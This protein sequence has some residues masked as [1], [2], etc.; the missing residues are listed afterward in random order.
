MH[1]KTLTLLSGMVFFAI[2]HE[3]KKYFLGDQVNHYE[4]Q[5][6]P[7]KMNSDEWIMGS[8]RYGFSLPFHLR[9]WIC[10]HLEIENIE[11]ALPSAVGFRNL[12]WLPR[13]QNTIY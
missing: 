13:P 5:K 4:C 12:H 6:Y 8:F 9:I 1:A 11:A 10:R 3:K 7:L 2:K